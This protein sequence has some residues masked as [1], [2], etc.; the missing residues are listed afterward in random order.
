[1][2]AIVFFIRGHG[3]LLHKRLTS[4]GIR[5]Q[6]PSRKPSTLASSCSNLG[7]SAASAAV[8]PAFPAEIVNEFPLLILDA[9][10][11]YETD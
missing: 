3:P 6:Y 7:N 2:R 10:P 11:E 4:N 1:M 8:S 9:Y 5:V